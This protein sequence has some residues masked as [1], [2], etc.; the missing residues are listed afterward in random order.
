MITSPSSLP[1]AKR[2]AQTDLSALKFNQ[3]LVVFVTLFA[4]IF[5]LPVLTLLLGAA[6]LI[7]AVFPQISPMRA[8]YKMLL[9]VLDRLLGLKPEV[10]DEDPRAHLFA[11]GVGGSFL[12]LGSLFTFGGW[13]SVGAVLGVMVI[14][15]ALLNLSQKICVGC[16]MYF[17]YRRLRFAALK[18]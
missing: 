17:Q 16:L 18:R 3:L 5:T 11:Q 1:S 13:T 15:L 7:G 4:V 12:L 8:I 9:P 6:M 2:A 10:V 14:A